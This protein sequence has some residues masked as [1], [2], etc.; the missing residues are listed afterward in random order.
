MAGEMVPEW[1]GGGKDECV[2]LQGWDSCLLI[3]ELLV[4]HQQHFS[5][6]FCLQHGGNSI[7]FS[8][9]WWC[10]SVGSSVWCGSVQ[11]LS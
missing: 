3:W 10:S 11:R 2:S 6:V 5:F 1:W 7:L 8:V 9:Q 4:C